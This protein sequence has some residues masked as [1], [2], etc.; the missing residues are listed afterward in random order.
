MQRDVHS[1]L[2]INFFLAVFFGMKNFQ[3]FFVVV[4]LLGLD[5]ARN[6]RLF[7]WI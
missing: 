5:N 3:L 2:Y 4:L 6:E 1:L 7:L